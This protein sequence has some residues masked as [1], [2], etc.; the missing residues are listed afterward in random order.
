MMVGVTP[1]TISMIFASSSMPKAINRM[2]SSESATILSKKST[3]RRK[4]APIYRKQAH[5]QAKQHRGNQQ[6]HAQNEASRGRFGVL[7]QHAI[8]EALE[9]S[10]ALGGL[11]I[12]LGRL[13]R[14]VVHAARHLRDGRV[15]R[16]S[17]L[18]RWR[19]CAT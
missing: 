17:G 9:H 2:G 4:N 3:K 8:R 13:E 11:L 12:V 6:Q 15:T 5:V 16:S 18:S 19:W 10:P 7:P 14:G 1:M